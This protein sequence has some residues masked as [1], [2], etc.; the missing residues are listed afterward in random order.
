MSDKTYCSRTIKDG[1]NWLQATLMVVGGL[2]FKGSGSTR[3]DL[4]VNK[5]RVSKSWLSRG[6]PSLLCTCSL[7]YTVYTINYCP[8]GWLEHKNKNTFIVHVYPKF[9]VCGEPHWM[10]LIDLG[11]A[12]NKL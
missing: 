8:S 9:T 7:S 4:H 10:H 2:G 1:V 6:S 12:V 3:S 5:C 11:H